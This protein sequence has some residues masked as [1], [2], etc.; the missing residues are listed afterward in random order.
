MTDSLQKIYKKLRND[1]LFY[2]NSLKE[3]DISEE[4]RNLNS[5]IRIAGVSI[6]FTDE[7]RKTLLNKAKKDFNLDGKD[8]VHIKGGGFY[9]DD[10]ETIIDKTNWEYYRKHKDFISE[11]TFKGQDSVIDSIDYETDQLIKK[12]PNPTLTE[13]SNFDVKGLTLGFVQ[14]GK[15][16]N[17]THLAAKAADLGYKFIIVLAGMTN[18]LRAQTQFRLDKELTG[19]NHYK[20]DEPFVNWNPSERKYNSLTGAPDQNASNKDGDFH[21]P[22]KDFS[23][24][25][26]QSNDVT[27]ITIKKLAR[28]GNEYNPFG[29]VLGRLI[30]WIENRND[31]SNLPAV[32]IIDDEADQASIDANNDENDPTTINHAIRYLISLFNQVTYVGYTATPFANVFINAN[33][34]YRGLPDL[35]PKDFIYSLPE[36][37]LYFGTNKFFGTKTKEETLAYVNIVPENEREIINNDTSQ[38]ITNSLE[39]TI[40]DFISSIII[41][42]FRKKDKHCGML[43][44]TDHRNIYQEQTFK[45][46]EGYLLEFKDIIEFKD[47][48]IEEKLIEHWNK[49]VTHCQSIST[50]NGYKYSYPEID[51][52]NILS[53]YQVVLNEINIRVINGLH[54]TLDYKKDNLKYLI[55]I[56]GNLMSRG[57]TIEGLTISYYLRDTA[58]YDT[59]LQ[60][61]RWFGYRNGYED[62]LRVYT[63]N[64]IS[65][66]FQYIMGVEDDLRKEI[67]RY[68][69]ER[70]TPEEFAPRVRAHMRMVPSSKMGNASI[71]KSY[72]KQSVQTIYLERDMPT[73]KNNQRVVKDFIEKHIKSVESGTKKHKE[74]NIELD[75]LLEFINEYIFVN[76]AN[77]GLDKEDVIR[78]LNKRYDIGEFTKFD[79]L[80][81][82][83]KNQRENSE[84]DTY[85]N[86][87]EINPVKRNARQGTGWN[88][89]DNNIVNIG[90]ISDSNDIPEAETQERPLLIIYSIDRFNSDSFLKGNYN[91]EGKFI[92]EDA[93][94]IEG[95]EFNPKG[96]ALVFPKSKIADGE[97]D[98]FQQIFEI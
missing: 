26:A 33:N 92:T 3:E 30:K 51:K 27:I 15:T 19:L 28:V 69:E 48:R 56:G 77:I 20:L 24:H 49:Y 23:D 18:T 5:P 42:K 82:G 61:G 71:S 80:V 4:V 36:P 14:S 40:L 29:S 96:I 6:P 75:H 88:K 64:T 78:Y 46:I 93:D 79:L 70:L 90:V 1:L 74:L 8:H 2:E 22:V 9:R 89:V 45:K 54:E 25:F 44:H 57:V 62:L 10:N 37:K 43:I 12:I 11:H 47:T 34:N 58:N 13:N 41:R 63:T 86:G 17:F 91:H 85:K 35:Y 31:E 53:N 98:Y 81:S 66:N 67:N 52:F 60:M 38:S 97:Y 84:L 72:S 59:L 7:D 50:S 39:E 87:L 76:K 83:R 65:N 95:L 21:I 55:C 16:A 32:L 73:L 94:L 68:Q